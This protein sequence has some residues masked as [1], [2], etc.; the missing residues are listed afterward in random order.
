MIYSITDSFSMHLLTEVNQETIDLCSKPDL[1]LPQKRLFVNLAVA[2]KYCAI[3]L[4]ALVEAVVRFIGALFLS[5]IQEGN[6]Y[7]SAKESFIAAILSF[8][9]F[10]E[11][12]KPHPGHYSLS[13]ARRDYWG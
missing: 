10:Y 9:L 7:D 2:I 1:Q 13:Q 5:L 12:F 11:N 3:G 4:L 8:A 6:R